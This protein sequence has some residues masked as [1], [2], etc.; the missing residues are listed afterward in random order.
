MK[1]IL[2]TGGLGYVGG[3]IVAELLQDLNAEIYIDSRRTNVDVVNL[4]SSDR[5][6]LTS[7]MKNIGDTEVFSRSYFAV[8]HLAA[9]NEIDSLKFPVQAVEFNV[10]RSVILLEKAVKSGVGKFIYFSTAHVYGSPLVGNITEETNCRPV[11]PYSITHKNFEDHLLAAR[12]NG[13]ID[14]IVLRLSN[15]YGSPIWSSVDRWTLLINDL[16]KQVAETGHLKLNSSGLQQRDFITLTDVARAV[17]FILDKDPT[18]TGNGLFNLGGNNTR[19]ILEMAHLVKDCGE[20]VY[21]KEVVLDLP[22]SNDSKVE[23]ALRYSSQKLMELGFN[24]TGDERSE[25]INMH[26]FCKQVFS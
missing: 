8:I 19:S 10:Q 14:G 23:V 11:H 7:E 22:V 13:R 6:F 1:K 12:D 4:F 26:K 9:L 20:E 24:W 16:C 17:C 2:V 21:N 15:A 3:R 18:T 25:I 5:V